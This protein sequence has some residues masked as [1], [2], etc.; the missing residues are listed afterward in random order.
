VFS[1]KFYID[2]TKEIMKDAQVV[3]FKRSCGFRTSNKHPSCLKHFYLFKI[4]IYYK[5]FLSIFKTYCGVLYVLFLNAKLIV[6]FNGGFQTKPY[7]SK[8]IFLILY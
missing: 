6:I 7:H 2:L 8:Y 4:I 1:S 3:L 5:I